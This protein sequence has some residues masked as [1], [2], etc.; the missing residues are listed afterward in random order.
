MKTKPY[1]R[2]VKDRGSSNCYTIWCR[3]SWEPIGVLRI[4]KSPSTDRVVTYAVTIYP[5]TTRLKS[6][7]LRHIVGNGSS[8]MDAVLKHLTENY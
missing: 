3:L 5:G 4:E 2:I 6:F 8:T 1:M 7:R